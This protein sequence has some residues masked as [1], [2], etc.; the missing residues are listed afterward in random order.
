MIQYL[1]MKFCSSKY[2]SFLLVRKIIKAKCWRKMGENMS[3]WM[4]GK[5]NGE[6]EEKKRIS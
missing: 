6:K 3:F 5:Q 4:I 1:I 2:F